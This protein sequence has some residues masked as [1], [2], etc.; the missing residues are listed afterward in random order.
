VRLGLFLIVLWELSEQFP[1]TSLGLSFNIPGWLVWI[2]LLYSA[3]GT[4]FTHL[5]GRSLVRLNFDQ[6]RFEADFRFG[7]ARVRENSEQIALLHGEE[8][9]RSSLIG[10]YANILANAYAR[11]K[12]QKAVTWFTAGFG[13]L[14]AIF[15]ILLLGPAYFFGTMKL[16]TLTQTMGAV[17]Q[18]QDAMNWF[19]DSY[20][21]LAQYRAVVKRLVGFEA[22]MHAAEEAARQTNRIETVSAQVPHLAATGLI[23]NRA[24][25]G[26][27]TSLPSLTL[28]PG[29]RVILSGPSGSGKTTLLRA[30]SGIWPFGSGRIEV[31]EHARLLV[32]PQRT[33]LPTG[34]L[35][36]ALTYPEQQGDYADNDVRDCLAATGL[37]HL[38]DRLDD[39]DLWSN[40]LSGGEQ[41]RVGIARALLMKPDYL[42]LDEATSALDAAAESAL[43]T[44]LME[45]LPNAAILC[46]SHNQDIDGHFK[47]R[48][49]MT[50]GSDGLF[51]L[52][53]MAAIAAE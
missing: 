11:I 5:I 30:L 2:A 46:V 43:L 48:V 19:V 14:S 17:S 6:Q 41:Q 39:V 13:Q 29:E 23:V 7:M 3:I 34:S 25:S 53:G 1:M 44:M 22:A 27:I 49:L 9:E 50:K 33:Y 12:R 38:A 52:G 36:D 32:L 4:L 26:Q 16:G 51:S 8:T 15:P 47:R 21:T 42:F 20:T 31:P 28:N 40:V 24:H 45:R 37:G 35:R 10:H 18:V